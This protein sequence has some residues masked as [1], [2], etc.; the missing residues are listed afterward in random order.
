M[1]YSASGSIFM[2]RKLLSDVIHLSKNIIK[3]YVQYL[4]LWYCEQ[5]NFIENYSLQ[6]VLL[7]SSHSLWLLQSRLNYGRWRG[8]VNKLRTKQCT[9]ALSVSFVQSVSG[10]R[11]TGE[12][13]IRA[14]PRCSHSIHFS[15]LKRNW[16][17]LKHPLFVFGTRADGKGLI[18]K[19]SSQFEKVTFQGL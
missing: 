2:P 11:A 4:T 10:G 18:A 6:N 16:T 12:E 3:F 1:I 9:F 5:M 17:V 7:L 8:G 14:P 13:G 19:Q 15:F